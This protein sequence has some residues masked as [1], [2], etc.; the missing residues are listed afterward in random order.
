[1]AR[2]GI[3]AMLSGDDHVVAGSFKNRLQ[4]AAAKVLP[5]DAMAEAHAMM[6][7]PGSGD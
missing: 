4:T 5:A 1:V 6:S 3:E 2:D 7:E